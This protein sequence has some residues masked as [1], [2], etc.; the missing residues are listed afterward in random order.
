MAMV[1]DHKREPGKRQACKGWTA[2]AAR[3]C[4]NFLMTIDDSRLPSPSIG[5]AYTLT[6]RDCPPDSK[7]WGRCRDNLRRRLIRAGAFCD[8]WVTE[9]QQRGVPHLHGFA[10]FDFDQV[11]ARSPFTRDL[12]TPTE[13]IELA[14]MTEH[15][16]QLLRMEIRS[17]WLDVSGPFGSGKRGQ[18]VMGLTGLI[19]WSQYLAKHS[20][21]SA[22]HYQR[23]RDMLPEGWQT[24]GKL[25]GKGGA[26][27]TSEIQYDADQVTFYRLRRACRKWLQS[28]GREQLRL[29]LRHGNAAQV[30]AA[31]R[32]LRF[33]GHVGHG[34]TPFEKRRTSEN[35]ALSVFL[36]YPWNDRLFE[37][38]TSHDQA[39]FTVE[40]YTVDGV[41]HEA[42]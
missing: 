30:R 16:S 12:P 8:H 41:L 31:K 32:V 33:R 19:G 42:V 35:R 4:R 3:R 18:Y 38:A 14:A 9:W 40:K 26:W 13:P 24:S 39:M 37:W 7:E 20:S 6:V 15:L 27:P 5:M 17:A 34:D 25:W 11:K 1:S 10:F 2:A 21:R 22:D 36:P 23:Q 28:K 29:G